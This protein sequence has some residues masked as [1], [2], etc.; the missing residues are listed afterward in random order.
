MMD[1]ES[2]E[3]M[4]EGRNVTKVFKDF[5]GRPKA[6]A[7]S[8]VDISVSQGT[9]FGLLGPN[10]A[11]K[12]TLIKIILG[13]LYCSEGQMRVIGKNPRDV[14]V[15]SRIGYLPERT[16][17]YPNLT[18][19]ETL[20]FF[21]RLLGLSDIEI[22]RRSEQLIRMVGLDNATNRLVGEFSHGMRKRLGLAQ[23]LLNDPDLLLLDEPTAGLDPIGCHEIK[24]LIQTLGKRGKTILMTSHLL[25]DVQ[26][27][28]DTIMVL[29]GGKV[30]ASGVVS[31]LLAKTDELQIHSPMVSSTTIDAV[32]EAFMRELSESDILI[33]N[34]TR[35]LEDYFVS[36]VSEATRKNTGTSGAKMSEGVADYLQAESSSISRRKPDA[37]H[38]INVPAPSPKVPMEEP[39]KP[40][41]APAPVS[42]REEEPGINIPAPETSPEPPRAITVPRST[43]IDGEK[44]TAPTPTNIPVSDTIEKAPKQTTTAPVDPLEPT[45]KIE[46]SSNP[47]PPESEIDFEKL[48]ALTR[49]L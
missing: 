44:A 9:I 1:I 30:Q 48:N 4:I 45:G 29:F 22:R 23:A 43:P 27:V 26:D 38:P 3:V 36:I 39:K 7:L 16:S 35:T 13:H 42:S 21:G 31:E 12:S 33:S 15:K 17:F 18:A 40:D 25:G 20:L 49:R 47:P 8:G 37:P 14:A 2:S 10:G 41:L 24:V 5:W 34:P 6:Q 11:G 46:S 19:H 32:K 28:C